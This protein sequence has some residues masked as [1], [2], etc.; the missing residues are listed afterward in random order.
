MDVLTKSNNWM[1]TQ[2]RP[3][4]DL[5]KVWKTRD[6]D[7]WSED[8]IHD[9]HQVLISR[10]VLNPKGEYQKI[11][12]REILEM[13]VI[14]AFDIVRIVKDKKSQKWSVNLLEDQALFF[15]EETGE[16]ISIDRKNSQKEFNFQR[17]GIFLQN[18]SSTA[19]IQGKIFDF[20]TNKMDLM[21]WIPEPETKT[22]RETQQRWGIILLI[23]GAFFL[24][25]SSIIN[26]IWGSA[27]IGLGLLNM[28]MPGKTLF[29]LNGISLISIGGINVFTFFER[30]VPAGTDAFVSLAIS[31]GF[32]ACLLLWGISELRK[33]QK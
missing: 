26:P 20:S 29:V 31:A 7:I 18:E 14:E 12:W 9:V 4:E 13:P 5:L 33:Y 19:L 32:G 15:C 2:I 22:L 3:T 28:F 17:S 30:S 16:A 24:L 8:L 27:L 10:K 25:L 6:L 1:E 11:S 21:T 23:A